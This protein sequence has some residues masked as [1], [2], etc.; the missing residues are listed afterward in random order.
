MR[1]KKTPV[2]D[3]NST[4]PRL[5]QLV[6]VEEEEPDAPVAD[7]CNRGRD[8]VVS[9]PKPGPQGDTDV[10]QASHARRPPTRAP[11]QP[12]RWTIA[13]ALPPAL[14]SRYLTMPPPGHHPSTPPTRPEHPTRPRLQ[15]GPST[16]TPMQ[17]T[18][19]KVITSAPKKTDYQKLDVC[20][21]KPPHRS[22]THAEGEEEEGDNL[23]VSP[24]APHALPHAAVRC[25]LPLASRGRRAAVSVVCRRE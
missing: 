18:R 16:H 23:G 5:T 21:I 19:N 15:P 3:I 13:P 24:Q 20:E 22:L 11:A 14:T 4:L 8:A 2:R 1:T 12:A 6:Q 17:K 25:L 9:T 7:A 10:Q